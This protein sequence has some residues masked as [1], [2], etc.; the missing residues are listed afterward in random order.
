MRRVIRAALEKSLPPKFFASMMAGR[1]RSHQIK[2]MQRIGMSDLAAQFISAFGLTVRYGPFKGMR[3]TPAAARD[4]LVICK[5]LGTYENELHPVLE[6]VAPDTYDCIVDVGCAEGYYTTGF[7]LRT[8][9]RVFG[10]DVARAELALAAQLAQENGVGKQVTLEGWC[11]S[12]RLAKISSTHKRPFILSDCE[13]YETELFAE[14]VIPRLKSSDLLI[15]L[16]GNAKD[17]LVRRLCQSHEIHLI[18][19]TP[20]LKTNL[21]ELQNFAPEQRHSALNEFR[22]D[23]CWLWA[24]SKQASSR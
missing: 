11:D 13:G 6:A 21:L 24:T 8:N 1:S 22:G 2:Y 20:R 19:A 10:F 17:I 9:S 3:Y 14:E 23:Q 4:R 15:E 12:H 18:A 5:L 7:A 16:H